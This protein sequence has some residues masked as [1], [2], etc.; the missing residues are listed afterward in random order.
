MCDIRVRPRAYAKHLRELRNY[1][2]GTLWNR[3]GRRPLRTE[4]GL[5]AYD[6][7][8]AFLEAVSPVGPLRFNEGLAWA[9]RLHAQDLGPRGAL[10]HV[11]SNG[12]RLSD[13]LNRLG[14]WHGLIAENIGT[15]E[16]DPRQVVIQLLVDDGVPSRGHRHNLFNPDLHQ[17][18]AGSAPHRDYRVVTVIDYADGFAL[19]H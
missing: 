13:R 8:I 4:E 16:E 1:F 6:E 10:E 7:A 19:G 17:A 14:T 9:A 2:E 11:G 15:L 18:G 3:P 5:A 12:S